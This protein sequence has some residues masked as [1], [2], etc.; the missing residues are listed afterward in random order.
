MAKTKI[1]TTKKQNSQM[2]T[3]I[4]SKTGKK[5]RRSH[6]GFGMKNITKSQMTFK[7]KKKR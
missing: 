2:S 4:G 5:V 7:G 1:V 3:K 6:S